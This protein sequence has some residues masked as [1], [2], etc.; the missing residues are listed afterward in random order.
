L[1]TA[2]KANISIIIG[3]NHSIKASSQRPGWVSKIASAKNRVDNARL[4]A[5][6][7]APKVSTVQ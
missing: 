2:A 3:A 4:A 5:A 1:N 6:T 7:S